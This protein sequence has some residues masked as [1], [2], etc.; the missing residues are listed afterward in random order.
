M[1]KA[2]LMAL[3]VLGSGS[4]AA[5]DQKV[6]QQ[7]VIDKSLLEVLQGKSGP[8][9][10]S[11][12]PP[13]AKPN[14]TPTPGSDDDPTVEVSVS[15]EQAIRA[16]IQANADA[17]N[18]QNLPA[19]SATLHPESQITA[20]MPNVFYVLVQYQTRYRI[21]DLEVE[22]LNGNNASVWVQRS[23]ADLSGTIE[24][25]I[26]YTLR[27]SGSNWKIFFMEDENSSDF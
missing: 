1:K 4:L 27:K 3:L 2:L 19:Y 22:E 12:T 24:Q 11:T 16:V 18:S 26:I 13:S 8:K 5:C 9:E 23:T 21:N 14:P 15:D 17:L 25:D 7:V 20:Y 10:G 6:S